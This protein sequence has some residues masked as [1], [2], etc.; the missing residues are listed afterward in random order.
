MNGALMVS[1]TDFFQKHYKFLSI[2]K[3]CPELQNQKCP[4]SCNI[5]KIMKAITAL[6]S[7][8]ARFGGLNL[9]SFCSNDQTESLSS[10]TLKTK[11]DYWNGK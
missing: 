9:I 10:T 5:S 2:S 1:I 8:K 3:F 6:N 11:L 4:K 7:F